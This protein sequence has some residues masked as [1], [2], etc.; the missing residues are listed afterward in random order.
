MKA[1]LYIFVPTASQNEVPATP[2]EELTYRRSLR[3]A[4]DV[5]NE[6][7]SLSPES[8]PIEDGTTLSQKEKTTKPKFNLIA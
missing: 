1:S 6:R 2:L 7:T 8:H 5:L 4:L 3:V